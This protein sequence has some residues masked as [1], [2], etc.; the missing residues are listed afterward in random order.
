M[1]WV[2]DA[3]VMW[4]GERA[5]ATR[6]QR[7]TREAAILGGDD[8]SGRLHAY[9]L[10]RRARADELR[11]QVDAPG[12]QVEA[13]E[14]AAAEADDLADFMA[15]VRAALDAAAGAATWA[16]VAGTVHALWSELLGDSA[17]HLPDDEQ[18][19][20]DRVDGVLRGLAGLDGIAGPASLRALGE[21]VELELADTIDRV[22]RAGIGVMVGPVTDGLGLDLDI[23]HI[24]GLAEGL[25]PA[26]TADDP[27]LPDSV[28]ERTA[29]ALPSLRDRIR[30]QHHTLLA[31]FASA[32]RVV[33]SFPRGDLRG[34]PERVPSRWLLPTLSELAGHPVQSTTWED[35]TYGSTVEVLR[36][37]YA[38]LLDHTLPPASEQEWRQRAALNGSDNADVVDGT[39]R[40]A[41]EIR[42]DRAEPVFTRFTGLVQTGPPLPDPASRPSSA[43]AF[44]RYLA[45]PHGYFVERILGARPVEDPEDL[46]VMTPLASGSLVHSLLETLVNEWMERQP[47]IGYGERWPAWALPRLRDLADRAFADARAKGQTGFDV[48]WDG[49]ARTLL[50][51]LQHWIDEDDRRRATHRLRPL[52]AELE[53]GRA[54]TEPLEI[55]LGDG[56]VVRV[57]GSVDRLDESPDGLH[58]VDY[59]T[60]GDSKY[61]NLSPDN[62]TDNGRHV[63]LPVYA[64]AARRQYGAT[65]PVTAEFWFISSRGKFVRHGYEV[66]DEV[67]RLTRHVLAVAVDGMRRGL[68]PA[69]PRLH[70]DAFDCPACDPDGLGERLSVEKFERLLADPR[71]TRFASAVGSGATD[72]E[73]S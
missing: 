39:V 26:R 24:V 63:Q 42:H 54:G 23:V 19:A 34:G 49:L 41:R 68:F 36:S 29:G 47:T 37:H 5:P 48:L 56:E 46:L 57:V 44:E 71:L 12:W 72:E 52:A 7:L 53:F 67:L 51:D 73:A 18:R 14:R 11:Q 4:R 70:S 16:D 33:L 50:R 17:L 40:A 65:R 43:T 61:K 6:W 60:G 3:P 25:L 35:A 27:L 22:G 20:R 8:W 10:G 58:L 66:D 31:A 69:R 45:C 21:V 30:A 64:L 32:G 15:H 9:A 62:P 1:A 13:A 2:A 55:D 38:A 28:R 59:K